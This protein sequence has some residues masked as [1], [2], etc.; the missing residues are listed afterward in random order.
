MLAHQR[1][2][3]R[4]SG[5]RRIG[6]QRVERTRR[7][8][9]FDRGLF[10]DARDAGQVVRRIAFES[11]VIGQLRR[12]E[13]EALAHGRRVVAAEIGDAAPRRQHGRAIVDDLQ[14]IE[15][16]R[17]RR[18]YA[19]VFARDARERRDHVVGFFAFDLD[20]RNVVASRESCARARTAG[21][22]RGHLVAVRL[23]LPDTSP[24]ARPGKPLSNAAITCV[25]FSSAISF[26][27]IIVKP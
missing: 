12:L 20:D 16:A 21:A 23:V 27:I 22:D 26:V 13:I 7:L 2:E 25:G 10:A 19:A 1:F 17:D 3:F 15:I 11:A 18:A 24:R 14:H 6:E 4:R 8:H 9:Q 5:E